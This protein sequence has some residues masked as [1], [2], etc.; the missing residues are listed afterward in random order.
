M[1]TDGGTKAIIYAFS[2]NLGIGITKTIAAVITGSGS[3]IAEAIHSYADCTNQLLLFLGL[4]QADRPATAKNPLGH[5]K[6]IYF[7]SFIVAILLFSM[8]GM[9][10][11]YQGIQKLFHPHEMSSPFIALGVLAVS[12]VLEGLALRGVMKAIEPDRKERSYW[13]W[14]KE[15][16]QS[17]FIVIFAED[18]AALLGLIFAFFAVLAAY[19]TGNPMYDSIGTIAIGTLLILVAA[20]VGVEVKSLLIGESASKEEEKAITKL[21]NADS[22][23]KKVLHLI[24]IEHGPSMVVAIKVHMEPS[25]SKKM[26]DNI[27]RLEKELKKLNPR[28]RQTFFE[29]DFKK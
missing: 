13:R 8:G 11:L 25:T 29:P 16:R 19:L 2:A 7:W 18:F 10:S 9:F 20:L 15:S 1:S 6:A 17:Q 24:T 28:I 21:I 26:I 22:A 4:R 27:N 14:F 5:G 23:V 12:I 3:M